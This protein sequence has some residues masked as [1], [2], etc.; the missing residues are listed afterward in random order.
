MQA[1]NDTVRGWVGSLVF[2]ALAA[3]ILFLWQVDVTV[4]EPA[5][6]EVS[7]GTMAPVTRLTP[8]RD[9]V[10]GSAGGT[11]AAERSAAQPVD[12]PE[13]RFRGGDDV[14]K[15][16]EARKL[17]PDE[18]MS[19]T[20]ARAER[21]GAGGK[22]SGT[23]IGPGSKERPAT[24]GM[25]ERAGRVAEPSGMGEDGGGVGSS[26]SASM[27]WGDGGTRKK[28]SGD[29][30]TYPDGVNVEAQIRIE[31]IVT[32]DGS[33]KSLKPALKGNTRLEEA[34]MKAVRLWRFE[35]LPRS[36]AQRDQTC[37]ITFNFQLQ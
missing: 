20:G 29:L 32:P 36:T 28:I 16:P 3:V 37:L 8:P 24:P 21:V 14:L 22:E 18:R 26:V 23:G 34:A 10:A 35:P 6:L 4:S 11:V 31:A 2:H 7:W 17:A 12:L 15:V 30:P 13:R 9:G 5:F 25:G 33:V 19:R 1:R 27:V